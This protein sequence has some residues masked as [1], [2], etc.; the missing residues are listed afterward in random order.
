[1][2]RFFFLLLFSAHAL[3]TLR[4][5]LEHHQIILESDPVASAEP[6]PLSV[7][8]NSNLSQPSEELLA[9]IVRHRFKRARVPFR[10]STEL[11]SDQSP[12]SDRI[13]SKLVLSLSEM[14]KQGI[15]FEIFLVEYSAVEKRFVPAIAWERKHVLEDLPESEREETIGR[16]LQKELSQFLARPTAALTRLTSTPETRYRTDWRDQEGSSS[17]YSVGATTGAP[18]I[19]NLRAGYWG[20]V[21]FPVLIGIGGMYFSPANRGFQV[22]AGWAWDRPGR[23][24]QVIG[25]SFARHNETRT[26]TTTIALERLRTATRVETVESLR[27]FLGPQYSVQFSDFFFQAAALFPVQRGQ[28]EATRFLLQVGYVPIWF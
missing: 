21:D 10:L 4:G 27:S 28:G 18:M 1:M 17:L 13:T 14:P 6:I 3:A 22:D 16:L 20:S 25:L 24:K 8:L 9:A 19:F 15:T 23:W 12:A 5:D 7:I 2:K 11:P 26:E